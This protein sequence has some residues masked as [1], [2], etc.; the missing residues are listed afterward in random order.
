M[1]N[2]AEAGKNSA[3]R[4]WESAPTEF[5]HYLNGFNGTWAISDH[6]R[7]PEVILEFLLEHFRSRLGEVRKGHVKAIPLNEINDD[8]VKYQRDRSQ[9]DFEISRNLEINKNTYIAKNQNF[10]IKNNVNL[11]LNNGAILFIQGNIKFEGLSDSKIYIKSDGSGSIIFE[12]NNVIIKHTNIENLGYP[13][14]NQYIL[15]GGLN[16][17]NSNVVLENILIKDS[18]SEDAINLINSNTLLKNIF[19]EN[20]ESDAIDID[21]GSVNFNTINCLNIRNDCLDIS[22]SKVLVFK[23]VFQ[24]FGDKGLSIG[25]QA[26][27]IVASNQFDNNKQGIAVKDGST[28][29]ILNNS[30][31]DNNRDVI[32]YVK[33]KM[34]GKPK[35]EIHDDDQAPLSLLAI[36]TYEGCSFE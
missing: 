10:L 8:F 6:S 15:Y 19:L 13:K 31:T 3:I 28:A 18:K 32:S 11:Q 2:L 4:Y 21:F 35:Y 29:C 36:R 24:N 14:L 9:S 30:F 5:P 7:I 25:E 34:Y 26:E 23:N 20:I 33:K 12:N 1:Y 17:I 22:G 27:L 16:F